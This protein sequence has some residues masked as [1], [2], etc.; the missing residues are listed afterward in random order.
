MVYSRQS[1][2]N[3]AFHQQEGLALQSLIRTVTGN[4]AQ[5]G[6]SKEKGKEGE[7]PAE[8]V[9]FA[10]NLITCPCFP[11]ATRQAQAFQHLWGFGA[12]SILAWRIPW[13]EESGGPYSMGLHRVR[14][15][16]SDLA[17]THGAYPSLRLC[18]TEMLL[19]ISCK[20]IPATATGSMC[21]NY[22]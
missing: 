7:R 17:C 12:P 14:Y 13:R 21:C 5:A 2:N 19:T 10:L 4:P 20:E 11:P 3:R 9:S 1:Q 6:S 16:W 8:H 18:K 22:A 15:D